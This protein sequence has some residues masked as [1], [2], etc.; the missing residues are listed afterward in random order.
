LTG[1]RRWATKTVEATGKRDA[2]HQANAW[3]VELREQDAPH[4]RG[5]FGDLAEQWIAVKE[6]RWPPN[7]LQE[8]RRIV[9]RNLR[10][11]HDVDVAKITTHTLDVLYAELAARGGACT[12]RPCPPAPCPEHG[13]RCRRKKCKRPACSH[14]GACADRRWAA[15]TTRRNYRCSTR[16]A[17]LTR[18]NHWGHTAMEHWQTQLPERYAA[19]E[20]PQEFFTQLGEEAADRYLAVRDSVLEGLSPNDGTMAGRSSRTGWPK[21]TRRP[22]RWSRPS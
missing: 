7:T 2:R 16:R 3:E 12:H 11:L 20:D 22:G 8:H 10:P 19:L 17:K 15:V 1:T 6:R 18:M 5:T 14:K 4:P 21:R 9:A 13:P